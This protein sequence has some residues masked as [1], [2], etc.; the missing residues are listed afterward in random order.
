[1]LENSEA[2]AIEGLLPDHLKEGWKAYQEW[3]VA[4]YRSGNPLPPGGVFILNRRA[5]L[6]DELFR[7]H[8][9][10]AHGL[11]VPFEAVKVDLEAD[12]LGRPVPRVDVRPPA[13]WA[14]DLPRRMVLECGRNLDKLANEY[15]AGFLKVLYDKMQ[16]RIAIRVRSLSAIRPEACP[17]EVTRAEPGGARQSDPAS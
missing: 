9:E 1:M 6:I 14:P 12:A 15:V 4:R 11:N 5:V 16:E 17:Q 2:Q 7:F 3:W 10:A 13:G 8:V